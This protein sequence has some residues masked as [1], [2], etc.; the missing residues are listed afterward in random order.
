VTEA[1]QRISR[2]SVGERIADLG[3][4]VGWSMSQHIPERLARFGAH[5][6]ARR[7]WKRQGPGVRQLRANLARVLG[8]VTSDQL[9]DVTEEALDRYLRYWQEA[10]ALP[11]WSPERVTSTFDLV[12]GLD[13]LDAAMSQ[14][15]GAVL[16]LPHMGNW[17]HAGAWAT[18]RYG[19]L[20]TVAE[21]LRP[22]SL[23]D[24]FVEYR[25]GLGMEVL[26][27]GAPDVLRQ[28]ARRL[29]EGRLVCLLADRD[30]QHRGAPVTFFGEAASMPTGPAVLATLTGAPL[31]PVSTWYVEG[32]TQACVH[33]AIEVPESS[34]DNN[35]R[36]DVVPLMTQAL[37]NVFEGAISAH[38]ADWHMMQ[39]LW[40]ADLE[41]REP[42]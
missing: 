22:E 20:S 21:R 16:A 15:R 7:L 13:R 17:D 38:P 27:L 35:S 36:G 11:T 10:F 12:E 24:R 34:T 39:R 25:E 29:N 28:L 33:E 23:Y 26:P 37:A 1:E 14:G 8:P 32:A 19:G 30:L 4:A 6:G 18:A 3:F 31:F 41:R 40:H 9:D 5:R 42:S 2:P